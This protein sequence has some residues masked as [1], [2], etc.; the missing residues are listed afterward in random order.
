MGSCQQQLGCHKLYLIAV[1]GFY[2]IVSGA[3]KIT[4]VGIDTASS[5][6]DHR[7][8]KLV[9]LTGYLNEKKNA[10]YGLRTALSLKEKTGTSMEKS[11]QKIFRNPGGQEQA[12]KTRGAHL[13]PVLCFKITGDRIA[14]KPLPVD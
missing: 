7:T 2:K 8:Q 12:P 13:G 11:K 9:T 3:I 14:D 6:R 10:N 1:R 5:F 4:L